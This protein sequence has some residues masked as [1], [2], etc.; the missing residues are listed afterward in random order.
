LTARMVKAS[1]GTV[2]KPTSN[3]PGRMNSHLEIS[4]TRISGRGQERL[5]GG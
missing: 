5:S 1:K 2:N 4:P 3:S